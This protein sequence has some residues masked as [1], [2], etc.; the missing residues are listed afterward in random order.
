MLCSLLREALTIVLLEVKVLGKGKELFEELFLIV[1]ILSLSNM[2]LSDD[3]NDL[4][5]SL[6]A[7]Y[8][9]VLLVNTFLLL[10]SKTSDL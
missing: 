9:L 6:T 1:L 2:K 7:F 3:S 5:V 8:L 10:T 4:K